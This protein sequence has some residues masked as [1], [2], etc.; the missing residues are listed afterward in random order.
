MR[1]VWGK[2][3]EQQQSELL[4]AIFGL[5]EEYELAD[6]ATYLQV[7]PERWFDW[8]P[9]E[10]DQYMKGFNKLTVEDVMSKKIVIKQDC[11]QESS[12]QWQEFSNAISSLYQINELSNGLIRTIIK[13]AQRKVPSLNLQ[14]NH[15][16][17]FVAA[18]DCKRGIY[19]CR[20]HRD[21]VT[22][23]C[24]CYRYTAIYKHGLCH[25]TAQWQEFPNAISSLYQIKELSNG[26][27]CTIMK[28]AENILNK[29]NATGKVPSS[30]PQGNRENFFVAAESLV[31]M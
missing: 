22:C 30:S 2:V 10:R 26:L 1:D 14:G 16:E 23:T 15:E 12:T 28:E 3:D 19:G 5:S 7:E 9:N 18:K 6:L 27:I 13:E 25:F 24:P 4:L 11:L 21:H 31:I 20:V 29:A 8:K 17:F